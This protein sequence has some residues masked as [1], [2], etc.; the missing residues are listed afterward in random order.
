MHGARM[1]SIVSVI[2]AVFL[3]GMCDAA[4]A[5]NPRA[6]PAA[7]SVLDAKEY[8]LANRNIARTI[9]WP[10]GRLAT[11]TIENL[12]A[13][14][15]YLLEGD[16]FEIRLDGSDQP[17]TAATARVTG[18]EVQNIEGGQRLVMSL[19]VPALSGAVLRV[20]YE[21]KDADF[22]GRKWIEMD[23]P[24]GIRL[25]VASLAVESLKFPA[26]AACS[27]VA[28]AKGQPVFMDDNLFLGL[29][30][31]GA[32]NGFDKNVYSATH[33]PAWDVEKGFCSK[34]A[35][36]GAAPAG[37]V[38]HWFI[39][40]YV[41]VMRLTPPPAVRLMHEPYYS[42]ELGFNLGVFQNR[43]A[44]Y[45]DNL[46]K[47]YGVKLD[48]YGITLAWWYGGSDIFEPKLPETFQAAQKIL[49]T[50]LPGC[51]LALYWPFCGTALQPPSQDFVKKYG[52]E[53][54]SDAYCTVG[55]NFAKAAREK[56]RHNL[57]DLGVNYFCDDNYKFRPCQV[58]GHGHR[59]EGGA[60]L[61]SQVEGLMR[62]ARFAK[63]L[64]PH[65]L[66]QQGY[67][68]VLPAPWL[69]AGG[70][71]SVGLQGTGAEAAASAGVGP[72]RERWINAYDIGLY[73][74][75]VK[76]RIQIPPNSLASTMLVK[77]RKSLDKLTRP[78]EEWEHDVLMC[79]GR[80]GMIW[81]VAIHADE[82]TDGEW[83]F[84]AKTIN[85]ARTNV[86]ILANNTR[87]LPGKVQAEEPYG[88]SH[89]KG[90]QCI[91]FLRNPGMPGALE[92]KD[93]WKALAA[94][95]EDDIP[96][97]FAAAACSEG[98]WEKVDD[99]GKFKATGSEG[100]LLYRCQINVPAAW[101]GRR[102]FLFGITG[103]LDVDKDVFLNG[104]AL[105]AEVG[106]P[107]GGDVSS[108][109]SYG[110]E[111]LL[112]VRMKLNPRVPARRLNGPIRL[113]NLD[114]EQPVPFT[115]DPAVSGF[116]PKYKHATVKWVYPEMRTDPKTL[117]VGKPCSFA[118]K[119][120]DVLVFA[121]QLE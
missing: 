89:T 12:L 71:D 54:T 34:R 9:A 31:P 102:I 97:D 47:K 25:P 66:I 94:A 1:A 90:D 113:A 17:V 27:Y 55:P 82:T 115:L 50:D 10:G 46:V 109:L 26:T 110:V 5:A 77:W 43:V 67:V 41:S 95:K 86:A 48:S 42:G 98:A 68:F 3:S 118:M 104:N 16:E 99:L 69:L 96:K 76:M 24:E 91:V 65:A 111:N 23:P 57:V 19:S 116:D 15:I 106:G 121:L 114:A 64:N 6:Q 73:T 2:L 22:F 75:C 87:F 120:F 78:V 18:A 38:S 49:Q 33:W 83:A 45:R 51:N 112:A 21:L 37:E 107:N 63:E 70:Y 80:G 62:F 52:Y 117:D 84:L 20:L 100:Y 58:A 74:T 72:H 85:W 13:A 93:G 11:R 39:E 8:R 105:P 35:V 28:K 4:D 79:A 53:T 44:G 30:W 32:A 36:W 14:R 108:A 40:K 81:S 56:I 88:Y 103:G 7:T 61:E 92:L 101:K 29:E 59:I 60:A 119:P